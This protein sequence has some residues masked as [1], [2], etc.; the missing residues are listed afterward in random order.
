LEEG[1]M[2]QIGPTAKCAP[3]LRSHR[4]HS[5][6][7]N[8]LAEISTIGSDHS[9]SPL[10]M[11]S[12]RNF[13]KVW[14]GI[15][16]CQHLLSLVV[17][18]AQTQNIALSPQLITEL[19]SSNVAGRFGIANKGGIALGRDADL[20]LVDLNA[21]EIVSPDA[22]QYRHRQTPYLGRTLRCRVRRTILRGQ[23]IFEDGKI[24]ARARGHLVRPD[25]S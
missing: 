22:L 1:D 6:L 19:T 8:R 13:F 17:D 5:D 11:K 4:E 25:R 21:S 15:S 18:A 12:H 20:T 14:G 23:T 24:V 9:P 2:K 7:R 3:P 16:G 10:E